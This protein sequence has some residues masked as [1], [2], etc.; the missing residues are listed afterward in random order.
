MEFIATGQKWTFVCC[1]HIDIVMS[2]QPFCSKH[3]RNF[4]MMMMMIMM[5]LFS[6][7]FQMC[8]AVGHVHIF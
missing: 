7:D 1:T 2:L 8:Q 6:F 3:T 5:I 4:M